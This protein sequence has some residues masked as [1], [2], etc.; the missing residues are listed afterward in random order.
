MFSTKTPTGAITVN[1]AAALNFEATPS[2]NLI[3][4]VTDNGSPALS[5]AA[6]IAVNLLNINEAP[7]VNAAT[8][9]LA[10][11]T[12]MGTSVGIVVASDPDAGQSRT[13]AITAG[14]TNNAFSINPTTGVI[15][16]SN[17]AA[18][19]YESTPIFNLTVTVT[20]NGTPAKS[21]SAAVRVNLTNVNEPPVVQAQSFAVKTKSKANTVVGTVISSDPDA[22]Q[23]R[24]RRAPTRSSPGTD[25]LRNRTSQLTPRPV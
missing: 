3:I 19:N 11:N 10:E 18:L 14:N 6:A 2:F 25:R 22:G 8:F 1:N 12:G 23:T 13:F 24:G 16:V 4:T 17:T 15:T 20:D 9:S 21:A 7:V 5:G